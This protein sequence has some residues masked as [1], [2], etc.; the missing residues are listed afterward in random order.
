MVAIYLDMTVDLKSRPMF[1]ITRPAARLLCRLSPSNRAFT[2]A[3]GGF[4][5]TQKVDQL[6]K[7]LSQKYADAKAE[8]ILKDLRL[9]EV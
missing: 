1:R 8:V 6:L 9:T 7:P 4:A 5:D 3:P 2:A